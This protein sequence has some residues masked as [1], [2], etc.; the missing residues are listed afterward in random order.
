M[1][2][3]CDSLVLHQLHALVQLLSK[4]LVIE[5]EV[6]ERTANNGGR[7]QLDET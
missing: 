6:E 1:R 4:C 2:T 3:N 5:S 7:N